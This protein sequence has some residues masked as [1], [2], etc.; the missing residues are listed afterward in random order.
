MKTN[1]HQS[2]NVKEYRLVQ[3]LTLASSHKGCTAA[4]IQ[5]NE[6]STWGAMDIFDTRLIFDILETPECDVVRVHA[7]EWMPM[8]SAEAAS[9]IANHVNSVLAVAKVV[10]EDSRLGIFAHAFIPKDG[11]PSE[12]NLKR[13]ADDVLVGIVLVLKQL[14]ELEKTSALLKELPSCPEP[15]LN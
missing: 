2:T 8:P 12:R 4:A 6:V 9:D 15:I 5:R 1:T 3:A 7:P 14:R 11:I 13:L 10:V